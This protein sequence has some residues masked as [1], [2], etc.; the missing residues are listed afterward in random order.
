MKEKNDQAKADK[1]EADKDKQDATKTAKDDKDI[2]D[3]E[4]EKK[5]DE[6]ISKLR[7][8]S[9]LWAVL[10]NYTLL[11]LAFLFV[12]GEPFIPII[13]YSMFTVLIIFIARF[14][15]ILYRNSK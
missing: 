6:Y 1:D 10:I 8:S 14:N 9:L 5:E 2:K 4:K 13:I 7:L 3:G 12:Y 11:L 15:Y